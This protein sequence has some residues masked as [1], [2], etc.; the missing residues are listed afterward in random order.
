MV[1]GRKCVGKPKTS[2]EIFTRST[3]IE[4]PLGKVKNSFSETVILLCQIK[5]MGAKFLQDTYLWY[6]I[7]FRAS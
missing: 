2:K 5:S 4:Q 6:F 7:N 1:S 3:Q